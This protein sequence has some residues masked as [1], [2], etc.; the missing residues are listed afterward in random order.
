MCILSCLFLAG[1]WLVPNRAPHRN[2]NQWYTLA[3]RALLE[4]SDYL[5]TIYDPE[6]DPEDSADAPAE[7]F[8]KTCHLCTEILTIGQR[9]DDYDCPLRMHN[10]CAK[11]LFE[12]TPEPHCPR[13][14]KPWSGE[15]PVGEKAA[16]RLHIRRPGGGGAR[17][18]SGMSRAADTP[19]EARRTSIR[20]G[21]ES[22]DEDLVDGDEEDDDNEEE[23][24]EP[25]AEE[26]EDD[27]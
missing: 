8:I 11:V 27:E 15:S 21:E 25:E 3:P 14:K 9:C 16:S 13:C 20:R 17:R 10:P 22:D 19:G 12:R 18:A 6:P 7:K 26:D 5:K 23:E 4:L 1:Y 2:R 24:A